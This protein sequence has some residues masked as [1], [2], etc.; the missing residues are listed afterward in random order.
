MPSDEDTIDYFCGE[1]ESKLI[2]I[3]ASEAYRGGD[4]YCEGPDCCNDPNITPLNGTVFHCANEHD[5]CPRCA[6][7]NPDPIE[8]KSEQQNERKSESDDESK[9]DVLENDI[10]M[11]PETNTKYPFSLRDIMNSYKSKECEHVFEKHRNV[12]YI[13]QNGV[14]NNGS[15]INSQHGCSQESEGTNFEKVDSS[16]NFD[17]F[18]PMK[19][20]K[21]RK[22][23]EILQDDL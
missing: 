14:G 8:M 17:F 19:R 2:E 20:R 21:K 9:L 18:L 3:D 1:C 7:M 12:N 6:D 22:L 11:K 4:V 16:N 5:Y 15:D 23:S 10:D 13:A